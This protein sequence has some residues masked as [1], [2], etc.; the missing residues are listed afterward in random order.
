MFW[1][2]QTLSDLDVS[3]ADSSS[4]RYI[5]C[6]LSSNHRIQRGTNMGSEVH[7]SCPDHLHSWCRC[8]CTSFFGNVASLDLCQSPP[9]FSWFILIYHQCLAN[10]HLHFMSSYSYCTTNF[11]EDWVWFVIAIVPWN[12]L[13]PGG[14]RQWTQ[15]CLIHATWPS[16]TGWLR[17]PA[18]VH[19]L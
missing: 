15:I 12:S 5:V 11:W 7:P 18:P 1:K 6:S 2:G 8:L 16:S 17:N 14:L 4:G 10:N 19:R 13:S 9:F 3:G